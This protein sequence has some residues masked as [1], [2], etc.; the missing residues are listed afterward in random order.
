MSLLS[1][2]GCNA[3]PLGGM[4]EY[5]IC[6]HCHDH[7]GFY[8]DE[9]VCPECDEYEEDCVCNTY[10]IIYTLNG[11]TQDKYKEF[12]GFEEAEDWCEKLGANY[13]E[14]GLP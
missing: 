3:P 8:D 9:K 2:C 7:C 10:H 12:Q 4:E 13:W 5:G 14:I 1:D 11:K 6:S